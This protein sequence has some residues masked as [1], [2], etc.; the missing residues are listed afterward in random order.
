MGLNRDLVVS[1]FAYELL[2]FPSLL[3][4]IVSIS[5]SVSTS[6][7]VTYLTAS[8]AYYS[9]FSLNLTD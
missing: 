8:F 1:A 4:S 2:S 3:K 9:K 6:F 5:F 7:Y